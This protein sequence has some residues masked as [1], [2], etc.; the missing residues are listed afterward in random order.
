MMG[1]AL[2]D[3]WAADLR[4]LA[5]TARHLLALGREHNLPDGETRGHFDLGLA[6]YQ[7][8]DLAGAEAEFAAVAQ[9]PHAVYPLVYVHS[10]LALAATYQ[11]Q[12]RADE[13]RTVVESAVA[14]ALAGNNTE[15]LADSR[16]LAAQLALVQGRA[17]EAV[18]WAAT[19]YDRFRRGPP[20]KFRETGVTLAQVLLADPT[21]ANLARA[22][23][24]LAQLREFTE[25]IH[26]TRF[27]VEVLAL[28]AL[29]HDLRQE[30]AA[31]RAALTRAVALAEPGGL[32]RVFVDLGLRLAGLLRQL[33]AGGTSPAYL[34]RV[35]A[36][37]PP[38]DPAGALAP[39]QSGLIEPLSERELEVL[40]LLGERLTNK[41]IA[42]ALGIS[43]LTVKRH[44]VNIYQKLLA[45]GRREAVAKAVALG[46]LPDPPTRR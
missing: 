3:W 6:C 10:S 4:S 20:T 38:V 44:T 21:A 31:A 43:P 5:E 27:L 1:L 36:A 2:I 18:Q 29:L 37:F 15:L 17:A 11:A 22:A 41:E 9:Q 26:A 42:H 28:E 39:D 8:N 33:R 13:A 32:I 40:T 30:P 46:L 7:Q 25:Q 34:D 14:Y 19:Q 12:G 16:A 45:G 24:L 35:L 23:G